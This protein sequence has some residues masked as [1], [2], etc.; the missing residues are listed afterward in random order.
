MLQRGD[1]VWIVNQRS[2]EVVRGRVVIIGGAAH[3]GDREL[4]P[5][6]EGITWVR[7]ANRSLLAVAIA[8]RGDETR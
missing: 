2:F 5:D 1:T 6:A 3:A 7:F 4:T 8:L